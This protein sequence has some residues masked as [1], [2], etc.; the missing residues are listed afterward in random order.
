ML[1]GDGI[2]DLSTTT[3][4]VIDGDDNKGVVQMIV[5]HAS[6]SI[7]YSTETNLL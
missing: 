7:N 4:S 2:S 1:F 6:L 5:I 3:A